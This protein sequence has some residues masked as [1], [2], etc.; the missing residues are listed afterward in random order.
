MN[1]TTLLE[2]NS[3]INFK[4]ITNNKYVVCEY[5]IDKNNRMCGIPIANKRPVA[6]ILLYQR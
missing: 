6:K 5:L 1:T 3:V 2:K 4:D